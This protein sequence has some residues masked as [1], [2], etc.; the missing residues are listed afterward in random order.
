MWVLIVLL[1]L[2][3]V[4]LMRRL[5]DLMLRG[6]MTFKR[7]VEF[8]TPSSARVIDGSGR[9]LML[10]VGAVID[11]LA[12]VERLVPGDRSR[13]SEVMK[14]LLV[15]RASRHKGIIERCSLSLPFVFVAPFFAFLFVA[16]E[17]DQ[18]FSPFLGALFLSLASLSWLFLIV[19]ITFADPALPARRPVL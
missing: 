18:A 5:M 17:T 11:R 1:V 7:H 6:R 3:M 12:R 15:V 8:N 2:L 9:S 16:I 19:A 14:L 10:V 4:M 13:A